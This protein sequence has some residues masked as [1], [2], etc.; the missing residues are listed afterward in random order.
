MINSLCI[1]YDTERQFYLKFHKNKFNILLHS[2]FVPI[3]WFCFLYT[4]YYLSPIAALSIVMFIL[5]YYTLLRSLYGLL[6]GSS[7]IAMLYLSMSLGDEPQFV[8]IAALY[9]LAWSM[10]IIVGHGYC[11]RNAPAF[12]KALTLNSILLSVLLAFDY[13]NKY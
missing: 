1:A 12:T 10:Q 11:E 13:S 5:I 3:E 9:L 6:I 4:M 8:L 2:V 7:N